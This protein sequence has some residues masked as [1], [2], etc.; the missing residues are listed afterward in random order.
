MRST[1]LSSLNDKHIY[2]GT[3]SIERQQC[4]IYRNDFPTAYVIQSHGPG[5]FTHNAIGLLYPV[6]YLYLVN[7]CRSAVFNHFESHIVQVEYKGV[8]A[9][10]RREYIELVVNIVTQHDNIQDSLL[11]RSHVALGA[12]GHSA[13]IVTGKEF[14]FTL[15]QIARPRVH[16]LFTT[17]YQD[18]IIIEFPTSYGRTYQ[19]QLL[20]ER[21]LRLRNRHFQVLGID[22]YTI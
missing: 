15:N 3:K 20:G 13:K 16:T 17:V 10:L 18:F 5:L 22:R 2:S 1:T 11:Q 6:Y 12:V 9:F 8:I 21:N 7:S 19:P 4:T 14:K